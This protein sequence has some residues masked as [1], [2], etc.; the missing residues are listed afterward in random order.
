MKD[1]IQEIAVFREVSLQSEVEVGLTFSVL[2]ILLPA[3]VLFPFLRKLSG[4]IMI[5]VA[6]FRVSCSSSPA[7][8]C[9][10]LTY[11]WAPGSA[12]RCVATNI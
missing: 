5:G 8:G 12:L 1:C 6:M 9:C 4:L 7:A 10:D 2:S 11:S 3:L